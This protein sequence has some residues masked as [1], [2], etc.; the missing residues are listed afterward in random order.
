MEITKEVY[1]PHPSS[2]DAEVVKKMPRGSIW[3]RT[4]V[5][6]VP[7]EERYQGEFRLKALV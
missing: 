2:V 4:C 1:I 3:F 5:N 7:D 6:V